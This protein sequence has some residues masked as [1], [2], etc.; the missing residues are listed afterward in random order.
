MKRADLLTKFQNTGVVAVLRANTVSQAK[1]AA[2]ACIKGGVKGIELTF[3]VPH[4]DS[5]IAELTQKYANTDV[6][7][8][9]GT[10]LD[11]VSARLAMI[12][13]ANF[14][15]SPTFDKEIAKICNLYQVPYIPGVYTPNEAQEALKYGSEVVKLFPGATATPLAIK[16]YTGPFPYLNVMPSGGV[17]VDNLHEWFEVGA[18]V[19]GVGGALVGPVVNEDYEQITQNARAFMSEYQKI[20]KM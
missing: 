16:E 13:G 15:V 1:L 12:A 8:G 19:V 2:D 3:T 7:I 11:P 20:K 18:I 17:S 14:I 10:V 4:A 9:A 6:V 5:A